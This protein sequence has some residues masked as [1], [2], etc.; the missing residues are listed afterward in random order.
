MMKR[1]KKN[2]ITSINLCAKNRTKI[3]IKYLEITYNS[4][5][6]LLK[7]NKVTIDQIR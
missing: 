3:F 1:K 4:S 5:L 6:I 7:L 2:E